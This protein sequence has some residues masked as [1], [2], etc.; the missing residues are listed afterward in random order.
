MGQDHRT[1]VA[2]I[3]EH[4]EQPVLDVGGKRGEFGRARHFWRIRFPKAS[5]VP[6]AF[7]G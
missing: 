7:I 4:A 6:H 3:G 2:E 1:K 5:Q